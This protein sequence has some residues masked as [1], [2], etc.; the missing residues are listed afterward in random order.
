MSTRMLG[1]AI[2]AGLAL[3]SARASATTLVSD[4]WDAGSAA[5]PLNLYE[6]YNEMYGTEYTSTNGAGAVGGP[7]GLD[8]LQIDTSGVFDLLGDTDGVAVFVARYASRTQRFGYY[9]N[10]GDGSDS[11]AGDPGVGGGGVSGDY[12]HLFDVTGSSS[13]LLTP[14]DGSP[15]FIPVSDGPI[16]FYDNTPA[17]GGQTWYTQAGRNSDGEQHMVAYWAV[18]FDEETQEWVQSDTTF[19]IAFEDLTN[20]GDSDYND[21]VIEITISGGV[22]PTTLWRSRPPSR[23][24]GLA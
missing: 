15:A 18:Y 5:D 13:Q 17:G 7:G 19:I 3:M 24:S 2:I 23:S 6:I 4:P 8:G 21:L 10:P 16:G 20:L 12:H 14:V 22:T 1:A 11:L 9:T